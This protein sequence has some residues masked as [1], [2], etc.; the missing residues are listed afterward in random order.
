M[1]L[2]FRTKLV[3]S[4]V[5]VAAVVVIVTI[6]ALNRTLGAELVERQRTRL[7]EQAR[8]ARDWIG[9][10]RHAEAPGDHDGNRLGRIAERL[11]AVVDARVIV[12]DEAERVLGDSGSL[13]GV[14]DADMMWVREPMGDGTFV[15]LGV[16]EREV[17]ATLDAM[18]QRIFLAAGVG[19]A[20]AV[21]LALLATRVASRPLRAMTE[22]A[23]R[24]AQ[25]D[26]HPPL[27]PPTRDDFG[28]L[29]EA[30]RSLASQL[31]TRIGQLVAMERQ[32]RDFM[33]NAS[34]ELRT[35]VT[36]IRG[37][38]E[39]LLGGGGDPERRQQFLAVIHRHAD[40]IGHLV[41]DML[42]LAALEARRP[43]EGVV[44]PIVLAD[45]AR[46]VEATVRVSAEA[47]GVRVGIEV[48]PECVVGGHPDEVE[49]VLQNLVDNAVKYGKA[50]GMVEVR[51]R[52]VGSRVHVTVADDGPGI[53]AEH[54]PR[55]F[56][57][58]YRVDPGRSRDQGG[59]GLGLAI[60]KQVVEA[61]GGRIEVTSTVGQG[62]S[63]AV[64]WPAHGDR[65]RGGTGAGGSAPTARPANASSR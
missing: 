22:S 31:E 26:Y 60:A 17:R 32:R 38:A 46:D 24:I 57:R 9:G 10:G 42:A 41:D 64:D 29:A 23:A 30:L 34:H 21:A 62:T 8:G 59:T 4:H 27:P 58:F 5:T 40:R 28:V 45:L 20:V 36:A 7:S 44:E 39:T 16:P 1:A 15:R 50:G 61:M 54:L 2:S 63:F 65:G 53:A 48:A 3:A 6:W 35:P 33:A 52:R 47:R 25:G 56:E 19:L 12:T 43:G 18:R 55:L 37:Y 51:G 14:A 11:A 13:A 49:R